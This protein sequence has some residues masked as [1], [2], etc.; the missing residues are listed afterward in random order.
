MSFIYFISFDFVECLG[1]GEKKLFKTNVLKDFASVFEFFTK[2]SHPSMKD[3]MDKLSKF[4]NFDPGKF[5]GYIENENHH[6][7]F[8]NFKENEFLES[9]FEEIQ[10]SDPWGKKMIYNC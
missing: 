8:F 9:L 4:L 5:Y 2:I 1:K 7:D 10:S 3:K 6:Q